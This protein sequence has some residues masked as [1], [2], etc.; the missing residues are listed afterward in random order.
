MCIK[1][2][3]CGYSWFLRQFY[4][5]PALWTGNPYRNALNHLSFSQ[6]CPFIETSTALHR[7]SESSLFWYAGHFHS[8]VRKT[9][10][11][12]KFIGTKQTFLI[13]IFLGFFT[14]PSSR[15]PC[16]SCH[17]LL[18]N[19]NNRW[20]LTSRSFFI[21]TTDRRIDLT[22]NKLKMLTLH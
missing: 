20:V 15:S 12:V 22:S 14:D 5:F 18:I 19:T 1:V 10:S 21:L 7:H 2:R 17:W 9:C 11:S 4:V 8:K 16:H 13:W 3:Q 6:I